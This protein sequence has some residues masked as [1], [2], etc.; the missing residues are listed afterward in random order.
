[1]STFYKKYGKRLFD[2]CCVIPGLLIILPLMAII[3]LLVYLKLGSPILFR[4]KRPGFHCKPFKL[5]KFRTM[6]DIRDS[7]GNPLS[8]KERL[9]PFGSFLRNMS[10]DELPELFNVLKGDMSLVGPR[11]LLMK[12]LPYY[13]E[14]E[15]LRFTV[16]PGITGWAQINGRNL[17][18]WNQ[19]LENDVWYVENHNL[20][21]DIKILFRT[22]IKILKCEGVISDARSI[23]M[24]LDEERKEMRYVK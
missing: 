24:D 10:L 1:M 18:S 5:Y 2:L 21:L 14:Q 7:F 9:T 17:S 22:F 20:L 15:N 12:Y 4:Q 8:D 11:P 13:S 19:R 23:M 16:R 3:S 6:K